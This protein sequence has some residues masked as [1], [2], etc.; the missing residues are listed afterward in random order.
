MKTH[1]FSLAVIF[2]FI[3]AP[4]VHGKAGPVGAAEVDK[5]MK[6]KTETAGSVPVRGTVVETFDSGGYTYL[7]VSNKKEDTWV[8]VRETEVAPGDVVS[9]MPGAIM[10]NFT[11]DT[12]DRTFDTIIFSSGLVKDDPGMAPERRKISGT[13]VETMNSGNYTYMKIRSREEHVWVAVSRVEV[14]ADDEVVVQ[15]EREMKNFKSKTLDRTF[16]TLYFSSLLK[17]EP[18]RKEMS[19]SILA[20]TVVEKLTGDDY[21]YIRIGN[22]GREVWAA[23]LKMQVKVGDRVTLKALTSFQQFY[24]RKFNRTFETVFFAVPAEGPGGK[25]VRN[26]E[27]R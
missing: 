6:Q 16:K 2:F 7:L 22:N 25:A 12:L 14:K 3:A 15:T 1:L 9:F 20:G 19:S 27:V 21:T 11:S 4:G 18:A 10:R 24:S 5:D 17:R 23:V 8:A 13:V 26:G